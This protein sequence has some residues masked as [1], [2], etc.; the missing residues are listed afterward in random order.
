MTAACG[1]DV[2]GNWRITTSCLKATGTVALSGCSTTATVTASL[3]ATGT[4]SY[5]ADFTYSQAFL[6]S[7]TETIGLPAACLTMSGITL[8]CDQLNQALAVTPLD[9]SLSS[10]HCSTAGGGGCNC[11]ANLTATTANETGTYVTAGTNL[12]TTPSTG[13]SGSSGYCVKGTRLDETAPAAMSQPGL[14]ISGDLTF[15]RQ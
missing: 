13:T 9:P 10:I 3:Q 12:V 6:L 14:T 5:A 8:T 4:A 7:G 1:G 11:V 15:T 2:V